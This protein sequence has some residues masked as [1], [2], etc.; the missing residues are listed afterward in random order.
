MLPG[1]LISC[2]DCWHTIKIYWHDPRYRWH[3][4]H[5]DGIVNVSYRNWL[6]EWISSSEGVMFARKQS[7]GRWIVSGWGSAGGSRYFKVLVDYPRL[8]QLLW[9]S[10]SFKHQVPVSDTLRVLNYLVLCIPKLRLLLF[11]AVSP[12]HI[13]CFP[14][15]AL[16]GSWHNRSTNH[17]PSPF[18]FPS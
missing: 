9:E 14:L 18:T 4:G 15:G 8:F 7:H 16:R 5:V 3:A 11:L 2:P 10:H 13:P 12:Q 1:I 6:Q 17:S